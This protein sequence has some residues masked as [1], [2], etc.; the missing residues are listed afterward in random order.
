MTGGVQKYTLEQKT[1]GI[2]CDNTDK[3]DEP[4]TNNRK[5][6]NALSLSCA[7]TGKEGHHQHLTKTPLGTNQDKIR[8]QPRH[9]STN[10]VGITADAVTDRDFLGLQIVSVLRKFSVQK[11]KLAPPIHLQDCRVC[12]GFR[13]RLRAFRSS[14]VVAV[15][16]VLDV[17]VI[18]AWRRAARQQRR[19][20]EMDGSTVCLLYTSDAADE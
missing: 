1:G 20:R 15:G 12:Q 17:R 19:P 2:K 13:S 11:R 6:M 4:H 16:A 18:P 10:L 3:A 8:T 9:A 5:R 7:N 14:G